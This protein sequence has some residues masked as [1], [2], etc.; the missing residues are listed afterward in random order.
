MVW[1]ISLPLMNIFDNTEAA[2]SPC[3]LC[4]LMS[5]LFSQMK[6]IENNQIIFQYMY[7]VPTGRPCT[8]VRL[9]IIE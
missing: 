3:I 8:T 6:L 9:Y 7:I 5:F 4:F 1:H 2:I